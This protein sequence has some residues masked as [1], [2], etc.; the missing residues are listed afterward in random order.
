[1]LSKLVKS[2]SREE[3]IKPISP[4]R[5]PK[6]KNI[7]NHFRSFPKTPI[8]Q[9]DKKQ[10]RRRLLQTEREKVMQAS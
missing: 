1:M 8:A 3:S 4:A 5:K 2:E 9:R 6:I 10:S 7:K